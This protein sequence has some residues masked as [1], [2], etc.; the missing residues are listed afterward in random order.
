MSLPSI[1]IPWYYCLYMSTFRVYM[2]IFYQCDGKFLIQCGLYWGLSFIIVFVI[3]LCLQFNT[4]STIL[5][6]SILPYNVMLYLISNLAYS[7]L[8]T[9]TTSYSIMIH[10]LLVLHRLLYPLDRIYIS[11][12]PTY[13]LATK[14]N[15]TGWFITYDFSLD[16]I[17]TN[18]EDVESS[19]NLEEGLT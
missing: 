16:Q 12:C 6:Y 9:Q 19:P 3:S 10:R 15:D 4:A 5:F 17:K 18:G 13:H 2:C 1:S 11:P 7:W 8:T 14:L